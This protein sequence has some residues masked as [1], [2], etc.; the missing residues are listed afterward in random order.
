MDDPKLPDA[1][2]EV[3]SEGGVGGDPNA[4]ESGVGT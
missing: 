4:A 2:A 3:S 1:D